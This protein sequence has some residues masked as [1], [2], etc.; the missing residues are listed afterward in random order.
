VQHRA[1]EVLRQRQPD[2][3]AQQHERFRDLGQCGRGAAS[4]SPANREI[5]PSE[6]LWSGVAPGSYRLSARATARSGVSAKADAQIQVA[7]LAVTLEARDTKFNQPLD[8]LGAPAKIDLKSTPSVYGTALDHIDFIASGT[9]IARVNASPYDFWWQNVPP[10]SYE[11]TAR[12]YGSNGAT[13]DSAPVTIKVAPLWVML[14]PSTPAQ[15]NAPARFFLRA[16]SKAWQSSV[17][18]IEYYA[19]DTL[20]GSGTAIN[21]SV[22]WKDIP[23]GTYVLTAKVYDSSGNSASSL[24]K[25]LNVLGPPT[26]QL[27][28]PLNGATAPAGGSILLEAE[29]TAPGSRVNNVVFYRG[30]TQLGSDASAPYQYLWTNLPLGTHTLTASTSTPQGMTAASVP[31]TLNVTNDPGASITEPRAGQSLPSGSPIN[32]VV[33]ATMPL[34]AIDRVEIFGDGA[35]LTTVTANGAA[36]FTANHNWAD[37]AIGAHTLKATAH[38]RDGSKVDTAEVAVTVVGPIKV[39]LDSPHPLMTILASDTFHLSARA[40]QEAGR[41]MAVQFYSG[42]T[43]LATVETEPYVFA[44]KNP[45]VGIHR[46]R[47]RAVDASGRYAD[48]STT[49][50]RAIE[51]AVI[52]L[53]PGIAGAAL[54]T[55]HLSVT[56]TAVVP[57]N[58][59][60]I[61]NGLKASLTDADRFFVNDV[62]L[63]PGSNAITLTLNSEAA[64]KSSQTI[65]VTSTGP[66]A[67]GVVLDRQEGLAPLRTNLIITDSGRV[68]FGRIDIYLN[69][70][71]QPYLT[72][73][74]LQD[75]QAVVPLEFDEPGTHTVTVRIYSPEGTL[76][77]DIKR[78]VY[79]YSPLGAALQSVTIYSTFL[80]RLRSGNVDAAASLVGTSMREGFRETLK[81]LQ[82]GHAEIVNSLGTVS[83]MTITE[84]YA[85]LRILRRKGLQTF[86]F[87]VLL[88]PGDDGI[89]RIIGM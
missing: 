68:A 31:I 22:E 14:D 36:N 37:A 35:L 79:A 78:R 6:Y 43:L 82:N 69:D 85:A 66:D 81:R 50:V 12:A 56:G 11:V 34:R 48:T 67:F 75:K 41:I 18:R 58:S 5:K 51:Q 55:E 23:A 63:Q 89:W 8:N 10:G 54:E 62:A 65:E 27:I 73:T 38:A 86:E 45:P 4:P 3:R 2:R 39:R 84:D 42:D 87:E 20:L 46:L 21:P 76:I 88:G 29:A 26:V 49:A 53:D 13:A 83:G 57:S 59:V 7:N 72:L 60:L 40:L 64:Q 9:V 16:T 70:S 71:S 19:G 25:T 30:S 44:W 17:E 77:Y 24:P 28:A 15:L 52:E 1:G 74:T 32:I 47:A 61:V 33:Q 80:G